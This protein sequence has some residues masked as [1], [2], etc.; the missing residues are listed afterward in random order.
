MASQAF[1]RKTPSSTTVDER[2]ALAAANRPSTKF[3]L[4]C[5]LQTPPAPRLGSS[6][7]GCS[8]ELERK[9]LLRIGTVCQCLQGSPPETRVQWEAGGRRVRAEGA[10]PGL[11]DRELIR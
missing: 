5:V 6:A 1:S 4:S 7:D 10:R 11:E 8:I 2:R 3:T 9:T